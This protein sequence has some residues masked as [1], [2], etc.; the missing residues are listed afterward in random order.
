VP[1]FG[2]YSPFFKFRLNAEDADPYIIS[3]EGQSSVVEDILD[4]SVETITYTAATTGSQY[5]VNYVVER[6]TEEGKA[7]VP[8]YSSSDEGV[9]TIDSEGNVGYVSEG[10]ATMEGTATEPVQGTTRTS[11]VDLTFS[12]S[13]GDISE[14]EILTAHALDVSK[15]V[16][17]LYNT[18]VA[19]SETCKNYYLANRPG[20]ASANVLGL[21]CTTTGEDGFESITEANFITDI[22]TP[23]LNWIATNASTK[24]VRYIIL[25]YGM[26]SRTGTGGGF[27]TQ[28][29][30]V[31]YLITSAM[32]DSGTRTGS[33][34]QSA[35]NPFTVYEYQGETALVTSLNMGT[36]ADAQAYIDKL[37]TMY[38]AMTTPDIVISA[39]DVAGHGGDTYYFDDYGAIY[40]VQTCGSACTNVLTENPSANTL[41]AG[42]SGYTSPVPD[43]YSHIYTAS[44]V[45]GYMS[46]GYNGGLGGSYANDGTVTFSGDSDWY[47]ITTVESWNGRRSTGQGNMVDWFS[48]NAFGGTGYSNTPAFALTHVEEPYLSGVATLSFRIWERGWKSAE[49]AWATR[50]TDKMQAIGDPLIKK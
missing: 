8:E 15:H 25:M 1:N 36:L 22:R 31:Q 35:I 45:I 49:V 18:N 4:C 39:S 2:G 10:D 27:N 13:G 48:S 40:N 21:N 41:Y 24:T 12:I 33:L 50:R 9:A 3:E 38:A 44:D 46:W 43:Q 32:R 29:K 17:L 7:P 30:G 37:A 14:E 20:M 5:K 23:L 28:Y 6:W 19:D 16:L 11:D 26:P 47:V 42:K 34:Y